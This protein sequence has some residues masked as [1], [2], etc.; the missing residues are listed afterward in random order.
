MAVASDFID[1]EMLLKRYR[2]GSPMRFVSYSGMH[3]DGERDEKEL[4]DMWYHEVFDRFKVNIELHNMQLVHKYVAHSALHPSL[5][6]VI[7]GDRTYPVYKKL[8]T[9]GF[10]PDQGVQALRG[11]REFLTSLHASE[12]YHFDVCPENIMMDEKGRFTIGEYTRLRTVESF[13]NNPVG[14][15][16]ILAPVQVLQEIMSSRREPDLID[17]GEF[18]DKFELFYA[19]VANMFAPMSFDVLRSCDSIIPHYVDHIINRYCILD[20]EMVVKSTSRLKPEDVDLFGLAISMLRLFENNPVVMAW[21]KH[22]LKE[23]TDDGYIIHDAPLSTP[24]NT[25][26]ANST[27]EEEKKIARTYKY[28]GQERII[29]IGENGRQFILFKGERVYI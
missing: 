2:G 1:F 3:F 5:H 13:H 22:V 8:Q 19:R 11:T 18:K 26:I 16:T 20:G 10:T 28:Q 6:C 27:P 15:S 29:R 17:R 24:V 4:E 12:H 21:V 25:D 7:H 9:L 23:G 14:G